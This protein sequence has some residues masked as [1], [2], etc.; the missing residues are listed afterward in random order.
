MRL[1]HLL[2]VTGFG[3]GTSDVIS[4]RVPLL[5]QAAAC[6]P[7]RWFGVEQGFQCKEIR[8]W[9]LSRRPRAV[10]LSR[11]KAH[12]EPGALDPEVVLT[13][14]ESSY[15]LRIVKEQGMDVF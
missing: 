11:S 4:R 5:A 13:K 6:S 3:Q 7:L 9:E 8:S 14:L 10:D 1:T 15:G 2:L 12:E